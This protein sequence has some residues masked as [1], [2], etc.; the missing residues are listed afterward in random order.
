[1]TIHN[2]T[3]LLG[4]TR[5]QKKLVHWQSLADDGIEE[6][7]SEEDGIIYDVASRIIYWSKQVTKYKSRIEKHITGFEKI[8]DFWGF[9]NWI[10]GIVETIRDIIVTLTKK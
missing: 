4:L 7:I 1:M 9:T 2:E 5:A 10:A 8:K 6:V 3:D